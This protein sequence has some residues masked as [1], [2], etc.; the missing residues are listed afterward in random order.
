M[1]EQFKTHLRQILCG[2]QGHQARTRQ[3]FHDFN[4]EVFDYEHLPV[5]WTV[6][7]HEIT[8]AEWAWSPYTCDHCGWVFAD[9]REKDD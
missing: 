4:Q 3:G 6:E 9:M 2:F 1:I 7:K 5:G 8:G